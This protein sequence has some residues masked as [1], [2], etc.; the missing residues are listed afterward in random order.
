MCGGVACVQQL[1]TLLLCSLILYPIRAN[2][3]MGSV[4]AFTSSII[5]G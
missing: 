5:Y 1:V 4:I 3:C 2:Q